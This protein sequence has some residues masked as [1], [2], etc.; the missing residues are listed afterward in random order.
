MI[1]FLSVNNTD[2]YVQIFIQ[3]ELF[4]ES[5]TYAWVVLLFM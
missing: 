2:H 4:L 5:R 3:T 1:F